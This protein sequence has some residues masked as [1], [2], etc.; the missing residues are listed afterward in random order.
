LIANPLRHPVG[1]TGW[2]RVIYQWF[3]WESIADEAVNRSALGVRASSCPN[4]QLE[5]NPGCRIRPS[6]IWRWVI[7]KGETELV[8]GLLSDGCSAPPGRTTID[9]ALPERNTTSIELP[10]GRPVPGAMHLYAL[11]YPTMTQTAGTKGECT[12]NLSIHMK[13]KSFLARWAVDTPLNDRQTLLSFP[14]V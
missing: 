13:R 14:L 5:Q 6:A 11:A 8:I 1:P 10:A 4:L 3:A 9:A 7:G 2:R 12:L